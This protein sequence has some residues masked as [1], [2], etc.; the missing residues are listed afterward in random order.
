[1]SRIPPME[2]PYSDKNGA[3]VAAIMPD[4]QPPLALFRVLAQS[5]RVFPRFMSAGV[6]DRGPVAV[7]DRE[8]VIHRTTAN[9]RSEYEW[10]VHVAAFGRPLGFTDAHLRATLEAQWNDPIF[11]AP[12][13]AL[14]RMC[15]ELHDESTLSDA[16]WAQ[17]A[18]HFDHPQLLELIYIVGMY[19]AVSFL[20]NGLKLENEA[21]APT[22]AAFSK[23]ASA[24]GL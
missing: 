2:P 23:G 21:F 18:Q 19:H 10:G 5:P 8:L 14:V 9:C 7:R 17:L 16:C 12:Q 22:F 3:L 13:Q 15:D 24:E 20:T 6:L 11:T 4:G 1:M